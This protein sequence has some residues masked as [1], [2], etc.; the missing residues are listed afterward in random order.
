MLKAGALHM[1]IPLHQQQC[2]ELGCLNNRSLC[3]R[4]RKGAL[5]LLSG[6]MPPPPASAKGGEEEFGMKTG[7]KPEIR[8]PH[9][10]WQIRLLTQASASELFYSAGLGAQM[11]RA[12][13]PEQR[14]GKIVRCQL[15]FTQALWP[16]G[17]DICARAWACSGSNWPR[18]ETRPIITPRGGVLGRAT[19]TSGKGV[20]GA[21]GKKG[22]PTEGIFV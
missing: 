2:Q 1:D 7:I 12:D 14:R 17:A 4:E 3:G 19:C 6:A 20:G 16:A 21:G 8:L 9:P 5:Y 10:H 15:S 11:S 22:I 18:I 13:S